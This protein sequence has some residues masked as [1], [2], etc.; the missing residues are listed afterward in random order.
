MTPVERRLEDEA[1]S[2]QHQVAARLD[3]HLDASQC[4]CS[5]ADK[6]IALVAESI[7]KDIYAERDS[8]R[9]ADPTGDPL[10]LRALDSAAAI[11]RQVVPQPESEGR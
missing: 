4:G 6:L 2:L 3:E 9:S 8:L 10:W 1:V 7:A 11:A 5:C